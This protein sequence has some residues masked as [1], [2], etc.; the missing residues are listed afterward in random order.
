[1]DFDITDC[2]RLRP[3]TNSADHSPKFGPSKEVREAEANNK[4]Y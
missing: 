2:V 1:M 3:K 4:I